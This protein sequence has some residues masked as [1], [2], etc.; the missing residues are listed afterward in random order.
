PTRP[1]AQPKRKPAQNKADPK[2]VLFQQQCLQ[3]SS[4]TITH[5]DA[6]SQF[7]QR[8]P[9]LQSK[10][11]TVP[12]NG[13]AAA[14]S[15]AAAVKSRGVVPL[16]LLPRV[17]AVCLSSLPQGKLRTDAFFDSRELETPKSSFG[18]YSPPG[19]QQ[20]V[21]PLGT[22]PSTQKP[23]L[24]VTTVT[25][26]GSPLFAVNPTSA[27]KEIELNRKE[28]FKPSVEVQH[29]ARVES[30]K[31][32]SSL[33]RAAGIEKRR[34]KAELA[35]RMEAVMHQQAKEDD[36]EV[37]AAV[38]DGSDGATFNKISKFEAEMKHDY[39]VSVNAIDCGIYN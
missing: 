37:P 3:Q 2:Q 31:K 15:G 34:K 28:G 4:K 25:D 20:M 7:K 39:Q 13:G 32:M 9:D 33:K 19:Y 23:F 24:Q 17:V 35:A 10:P 36:M 18:T 27:Q 14:K 16:L 12:V 30:R 22:P 29:N 1:V 21:T 38:S 26:T 5:A 8:F 6:W 11:Y